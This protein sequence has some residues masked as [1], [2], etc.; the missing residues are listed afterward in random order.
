MDDSKGRTLALIRERVSGYLGFLELEEEMGLIVLDHEE[1]KETVVETLKRIEVREAHTWKEILDNFRAHR[2]TFFVV[3]EALSKEVYDIVAQYY[4]RP[5]TI[6]IMDRETMELQTVSFDKEEMSFLL[7]ATA[8][9]LAEIE[10]QFSIRDK[11][12]LTERF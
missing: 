12:G 4:K 7:V 1:L 2:P 11:V 8:T 5:G 3:E 9:T 6:Q 10:E